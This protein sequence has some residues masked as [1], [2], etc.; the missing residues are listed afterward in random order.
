MGVGIFRCSLAVCLGY[1]LF[2]LSAI[3]DAAL[4][5]PWGFLGGIINFAIAHYFYIR[6]VPTV[7]FLGKRPSLSVI[8]GL[9]LYSTVLI[10]WY[11]L[12]RP[13]LTDPVL[14]VGVPV[15]VC[16]LS[17]TVSGL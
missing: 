4:V 17:T 12:L 10:V 11:F 9:I 16:W 6:S 3:G 5:W 2:V 15:Y 7:H 14:S 1:N 13:G 8:I